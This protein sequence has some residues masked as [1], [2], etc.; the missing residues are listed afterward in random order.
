M[1]DRTVAAWL[2]LLLFGV[3][4]LSFS[5]QLYSH[6]SMLMF[7]VTESFVKRGEFNAD[8]MW[9]IYKARSELGPDGESYSKTVLR[10]LVG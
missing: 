10:G 1:S 2:A 7:S 3:Y 6:D 5:G 8:Q 4:L 9:T